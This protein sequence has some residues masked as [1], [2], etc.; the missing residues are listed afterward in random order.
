MIPPQMSMHSGRFAGGP[1]PAWLVFVALGWEDEDDLGYSP[2]DFFD[3]SGYTDFD[4]DDGYADEFDTVDGEDD[5]GDED[6]NVE[7]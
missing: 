5:E 3:N 7:F 2:D 1:G 6:N 4:D